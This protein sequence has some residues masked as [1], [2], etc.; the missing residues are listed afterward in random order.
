MRTTIT[1]ED[2]THEFAAYYARSR[3]ISLSTAINEL[4]RKAETAPAAEPEHFEFERSPNGLPLLPRTGRT[5]TCEM[6]K[7]LSEDEYDPKKFA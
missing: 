2:E 4:I 7:E 3:G 5:I 6:V 1:L